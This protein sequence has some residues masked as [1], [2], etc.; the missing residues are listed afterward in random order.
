MNKILKSVLLIDDNKADNFIHKAY[1]MKHG[2][3]ETIEMVT[4]G[5]EALKFLTSKASGEYPRPELIFLDINM[6]RMN[7][8]EFLEEYDLWGM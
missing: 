1:I 4:G 7:G 2:G 3:V 5:E 8:W 6:P